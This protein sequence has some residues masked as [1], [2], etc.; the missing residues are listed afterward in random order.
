[1]S[2]GSGLVEGAAP[3]SS[4]AF[5]LFPCGGDSEGVGSGGAGVLFPNEVQFW[6]DGSK[7]RSLG[8]P[9]IAV[10]PPAGEN[11]GAVDVLFT[12]AGGEPA[13][14]HGPAP[15]FVALGEFPPVAIAPGQG[16]AETPAGFVAGAVRPPDAVRIV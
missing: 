4:D 12:P 16:G 5:T 15:P 1:V 13:D 7:L 10:L 11:R 6:F 14:V 3:S 2:N 9:L 8:A